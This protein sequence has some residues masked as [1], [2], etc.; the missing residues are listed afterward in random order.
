VASKV[1][2]RGKSWQRQT[3]ATFD[4][5]KWQKR[6]KISGKQSG[7]IHGLCDRHLHGIDLEGVRLI[8]HHQ[9]W[10]IR[11][12]KKCTRILPRFKAQN[13]I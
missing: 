11:G 4:H 2:K 12:P 8:S 3:F 13:T 1:A 9:K 6:G 5:L 7:K 10:Q